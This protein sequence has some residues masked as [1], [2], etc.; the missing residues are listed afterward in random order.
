ML[1]ISLAAAVRSTREA[2]KGR[3]AGASRTSKRKAPVLA[4]EPD[5]APDS[6]S[7][8]MEIDQAKVEEQD[9]EE[10][11]EPMTPEQSDPETDGEDDA[12]PPSRAR[13]SETLRS[14]SGVARGS[15]GEATGSKGVPPPRALPFAN[16]MS[17]RRGNVAEA[18]PPPIAADN[19]DGNDETEDEEL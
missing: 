4:A 14:S 15:K 8:Q 11:P 1:N 10:V 12:A 5:V 9:N 7:D 19:E 13:S 2:T 16:R 18:Q 6:D 17:T 3:K